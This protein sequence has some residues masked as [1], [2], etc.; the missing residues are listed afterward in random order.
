MGGRPRKAPSVAMDGLGQYLLEN[1]LA[2]KKDDQKV[3]RLQGASF[4]DGV[5]PGQGSLQSLGKSC[6]RVG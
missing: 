5:S 6:G 1:A 2:E 4:E 3:E